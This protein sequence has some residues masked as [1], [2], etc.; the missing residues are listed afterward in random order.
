MPEG[1]EV[2]ILTENLNKELKGKI[3]EDFEI[4]STSRYRNKAPDN[5]VIFKEKLPLE[6]KGVKNKGKLI[7][8][9]F[10]KNFSLLNTLGMSGGWSKT[11]G[12][13]TSLE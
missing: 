6:I 2:T 9:L 10:S 3:I 8:F 4:S 13:H 12:K 5:F 7:Y 1:P 11:K